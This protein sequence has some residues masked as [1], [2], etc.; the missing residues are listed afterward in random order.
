MVGSGHP[1]KKA[2]MPV[3]LVNKNKNIIPYHCDI[4]TSELPH[5]IDHYLSTPLL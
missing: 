2:D 4:R 1:G 5:V 3:P